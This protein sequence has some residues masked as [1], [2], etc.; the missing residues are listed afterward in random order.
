M[1]NLLHVFRYVPTVFD[2]YNKTVTSK[3]GNT[4]KLGIWDTAGTHLPSLAHHRLCLRSLHIRWLHDLD[5]CRCRFTC[6]CLVT[7]PGQEDFDRMRAVR[8]EG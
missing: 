3:V 2:N 1:P 5:S 6:S 7:L 4:Y 8:R